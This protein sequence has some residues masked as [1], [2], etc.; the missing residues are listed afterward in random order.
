VTEME[1]PGRAYQ[2]Q[3]LE[4]LGD[5]DPALVQAQTPDVIRQVVADARDL[6]RRRPA[7]GEFSLAEV[8]GHLVDAELVSST[9]YRWILAQDEPM[10]PGYEQDDWVRVS[11]YAEA[12]PGEL[13]EVFRVVRRINLELWRRTP[14]ALRSRVGHHSER[15]PESYDLSFRLVAGHDRLHL[16]QA[17]RTLELLQP[18]GGSVTG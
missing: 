17:R 3:L 7:P 13:I 16:E 10:L 11:G 4:L 1:N 18:E 8:V 12:D 15:G 5:E 14:P 2:L 6:V 9:R